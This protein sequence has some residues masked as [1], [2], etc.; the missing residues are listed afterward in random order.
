MIDRTPKPCLCPR[1]NHTHGQYVTYIQDKCRCRPCLDAKLARQRSW[2]RWRGYGKEFLVDAEPA[3][4]HVRALMD[5]GMG[6]QR[7][8][9]H[10]GLSTSTVRLLLYGRPG[11]NQPPTR[12]LK[13]QSAAALLAVTLDH[14]PRGLVDGTGTARRIQALM[15]CGW[16]QQALGARLGLSRQA[17]SLLAQGGKA[18]RT[19][20]DAVAALYDLLWDRDPVTDGGLTPHVAARAKRAAARR[21]WAPPLAWDDDDIADP[22]AVP[23]TTVDGRG[24]GHDRHVLQRQAE[25]DEVAV[26]RAVTGDNVRLTRAERLTAVQE[27]HSRGLNDGEIGR[28]LRIHKD[29]VGRDRR[30]L[31]LPANVPVGCHTRTA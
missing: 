16:T 1:A 2:K 5:A 18:T 20:A 22:T 10:A 8:A 9:D 30:T 7:I 23:H 11:R 25:V 3:H 24:Q 17:V 14:A 15:A 12:R 6:W 13:P 27:L 28:T 4:R 26:L 21:G 31:N 19:S 29:Q